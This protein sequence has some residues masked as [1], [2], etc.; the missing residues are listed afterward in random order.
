[1]NKSNPG[2]QNGRKILALF[3]KLKTR[4]KLT[5]MEEK[6]HPLLKEFKDKLATTMEFGQEMHL[7][8]WNKAR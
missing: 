6:N 4:E 8:R 7:P 5:M 2:T 3:K 1:M